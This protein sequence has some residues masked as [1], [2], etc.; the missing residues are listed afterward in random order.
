MRRTKLGH[1]VWIFLCGLLILV[2]MKSRIIYFL[3]KLLCIETLKNGHK[4]VQN[5]TKLVK[6]LVT[7]FHRIISLIKRL[8]LAQVNKRWSLTNIWAVCDYE[9]QQIN[10]VV[11]IRRV[12]HGLSQTFTRVTTNPHVC[13]KDTSFSVKLHLNSQHKRFS[14][15]HGLNA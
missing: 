10:E 2:V 8:C 5:P 15:R 14:S 13:K 9:Q 6:W 1:I 12:I 3:T 11:V 4:N 7:G